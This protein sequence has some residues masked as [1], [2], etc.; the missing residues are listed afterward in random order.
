MYPSVI[1]KQ[2]SSDIMTYQKNCTLPDSMLEQIV[3]Q[4]LG[5]LLGLIRIVLNTA[6][7]AEREQYLGAVS[8]SANNVH[9]SSG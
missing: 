3:E 6:M 8:R 2:P 4:G 9:E 7:Q 1:A 5:I